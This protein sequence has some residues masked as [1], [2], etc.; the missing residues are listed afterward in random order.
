MEF[1]NNCDSSSNS[2]SD[3]IC[4]NCK[5]CKSGSNKKVLKDLKCKKCDSSIEKLIGTARICKKCHAKKSK[6]YYVNKIQPTKTY[7]MKHVYDKL[8]VTEE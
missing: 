8:Y 6:E 1:N 7:I 3:N 5:K 4:K 2:G